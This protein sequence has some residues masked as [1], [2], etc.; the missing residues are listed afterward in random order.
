MYARG[1]IVGLTRGSGKAHIAR[2]VLDSIAFQVTDLVRAMNADAPCPITTLRV[3]GGA[4]VS[5]ILMQIQAD[6]LRTP[7]DR[8]TQV[9]TT[10]F[11]AA[12]L[13]GLAVGV[14]KDLEE[15][16]GLRRS[17]YVFRPLR[18]EVECD[19]EY[20]QWRRAVERAQSWIENEL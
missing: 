11:G 2:A 10:A 8:P 9:E 1:T 12:A 16:E 6:L 20:R 5:N 13:A 18:D 15:L 7:V 4:S 14:W 3:D 19:R 17:Q